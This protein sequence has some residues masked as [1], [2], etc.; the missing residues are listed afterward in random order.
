MNS[1]LHLGHIQSTLV[2]YS[3]P[4]EGYKL[5]FMRT[6]INIT[7][8]LINI[9]SFIEFGGGGGGNK[10]VLISRWGVEISTAIK[11][12]FP[13]IHCTLGI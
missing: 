6:L 3:W 8:K 7:Y 9:I 1:H 12:Y 4:V 13:G 11:K 2:V 10:K 5:Y